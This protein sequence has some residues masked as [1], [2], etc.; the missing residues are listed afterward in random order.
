[1]TK[2]GTIGIE[3]ITARG[4]V[5]SLRD[6][7]TRRTDRERSGPGQAGIRGHTEPYGTVASAA[8]AR[9][10]RDPWPS[11]SGGPGTVTIS[12][13]AHRDGTSD[14]TKGGTIGIEGVTARGRVAS[15]RDRD[16]CRSD[17]ERSGPGQTTIRSHA[18]CSGA[19]AA[20]ACA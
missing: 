3:G 18:E 20:T 4:W 13:H 2:G 19:G 8:G 7:D 5:A 10:D 16:S 6:R 9:R 12:G 15:L 11:R 14:V 17:R 1:V